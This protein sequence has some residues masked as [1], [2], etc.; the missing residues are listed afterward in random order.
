MKMFRVL[1]LSSLF[2]AVL[3][4]CSKSDK[5][6]VPSNDKKAKLTFTV[7]SEFHKVEG[8]HFEV[9]VSGADT[10]GNFI[11]WM[12]NGARKTGTNVSVGDDDFNNGK[13]ITIESASDFFGGDV[14]FGGFEGSVTPFTVTWKIE[15]NGTTIEQGTQKVVRDMSPTFSKS[16]QLKLK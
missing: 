3:S 6:G 1:L 12:V 16:F 14:Y 15:V 8:D 11:D 4:A 5:P 2:L 7:S 13:T 10:K 9:T